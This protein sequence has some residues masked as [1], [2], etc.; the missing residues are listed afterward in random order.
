MQKAGVGIVGCGAISGVY[1]DTL[2]RATTAQVRCVTDLDADKA[3]R[4]A[5]KHGFEADTL[6]GLL[7]RPDI[8][9][10]LNLTVPQAHFAVAQTAVRARKS[11]YNEKPLSVKRE[12][13]AALLREA[14]ERGVLVGCAPDTVLGAGVQTARQAIDDGLIGKPTGFNA[15]MMC[16][17]HESWHP[18][19]AFYYEVGGGPLFDMGPYYLSALV[20]LLGPFASVSALAAKAFQTRT[21]TSAPLAGTPM[22]VET[23]T[24]LVVGLQT[25]EGVVGQFT[26]SFD[27]MAPTPLPWIEIYG[28][29][30][31]LSVP[32]PN[33]FGGH[34]LIRKAGD[35][36]WTQLPVERPFSDNLRG[37]GV[38][39]MA[40]AIHEGRDCLA[41]GALA[42]H[43]LDVMHAA[44]ESAESGTR[45]DVSASGV[46]PGTM[47]YPH[48]HLFD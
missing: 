33:G 7:A 19:P 17:G 5:E 28:T 21:I 41:S 38:A 6:D 4:I 1:L 25:Q 11:V 46:R 23:P 2:A 43:V 14:S 37:L 24:H 47:T 27:T 42:Y 10:V 32:D 40:V 13:G 15:F 9:I 39:E 18:S 31:T 35:T 22:P 3:A 8:D 26:A 45:V 36:E 16:P 30:G 20:T 12:D 34:P 44:H 48:G 29:H